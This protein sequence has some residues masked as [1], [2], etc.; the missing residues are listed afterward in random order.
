MSLPTQILAAARSHDAQR[1]S[2]NP[3]AGLVDWVSHV[4]NLA[5]WLTAVVAG[6][7]A[8]GWLLKKIRRGY[9]TAKPWVARAKAV[10]ELAEYE[11]Q[12]NGGGS[13]KDGVA[14]IIPMRAEITAIQAAATALS[15]KFSIH[16]VQAAARDSR[17][18]EVEA[19]VTYLAED[20]HAVENLSEAM[21]PAIRATPHECDSTP[22][23]ATGP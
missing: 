21:G 16:L 15:D 8:I 23:E 9:L 14:Q 4:D 10:V 5:L 17:L 6:M 1:T 18:T 3:W 20:H 22:D 12:H 7:G 11:L 2:D 13:I 19:A